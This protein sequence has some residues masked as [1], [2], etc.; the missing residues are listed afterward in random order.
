M[1]PTNKLLILLLVLAA[2]AGVFFYRGRIFNPSPLR[3]GER[4]PFAMVEFYGD[5]TLLLQLSNNLNTAVNP[6][7]A[8]VPLSDQTLLFFMGDSMSSFYLYRKEDGRQ[9]RYEM[10]DGKLRINGQLSAGQIQVE[11][12]E[13]RLDR[14]VNQME[15][16]AVRA[17][18]A[19]K[20]VLVTGAAGSIG[21]ELVRQLADMHVSQLTLVDIAESGLY[22]VQMELQGKGRAANL[23]VLVADVRDR[24]RMQEVFAA[25]RPQ[26][27]FHAAAY[28]HVPLMEA[29]PSEAVH[30]NVGW[31]RI[32]AELAA[33]L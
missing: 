9:I 12:I 2:G 17:L 8:A 24:T 23:A 10:A 19:G 25:Q 21:S 30:T 4:F 22:D 1:K 27:V 31:T 32:V 13:D 5:T 3:L 14:P 11:R 33:E 15:Q 18:L 16:A 26:V 29:Q 28:K 7:G 20:R 6:S